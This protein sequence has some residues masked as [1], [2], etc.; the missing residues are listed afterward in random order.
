MGN[1]ISHYLGWQD[2]ESYSEVLGSTDNIHSENVNNQVNTL[3]TLLDADKDNFVTKAELKMYFEQLSS[4][5][6][7]NSDGIVSKEEL[8]DYV[9]N[10]LELSKEEVE[11]WKNSYQVLF[12]EHEK[13]KESLL[14]EQGR[15]LEVSNISNQV[16]K[17]YIQEEI[18]E[19]DGNI[20]MLPDMIE[21]RLYLKLYRT[22][23]KS[24]EK[25]SEKTSFDILGH[26]VSFAIQPIIEE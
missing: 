17:K 7:A 14:F 20:K 16:L 8:E 6:D 18:I 13:L 24:I 9:E 11:R 22:M 23:L 5:I 26:K 1:T 25:L 2:P 10:K 19:T 21:R 15:V 4:K 12:E 3:N